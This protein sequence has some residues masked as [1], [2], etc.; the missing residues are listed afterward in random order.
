[1][2]RDDIEAKRR[3][4]VEVVGVGETKPTPIPDGDLLNIEDA[5]KLLN[6]KVSQMRGLLAKGELKRVKVGKTFF[7]RRSSLL[8][9][10]DRAEE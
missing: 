5:G 6:L 7:F 10:A 3:A 9:W 2:L 4:I 8:K 1:M